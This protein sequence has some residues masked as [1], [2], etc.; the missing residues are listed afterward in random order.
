MIP[1]IILAAGES[2]RMGKPKMLLP[3]GQSTVLQTVIAAF[4]TAGVDQILIVCGRW[5]EHIRALVGGEVDTLFNADY[6][7]G[8]MLKSLQAG[9]AALPPD[10]EAALIGLG[11]QP[12]VEPEVV[13]HILQVYQ[14]TQAALVVPSYQMR[15]GHPWLAARGLWEEIEALPPADTLRNFLG[16]HS[17]SIVYVPLDSP[18]I[19]QDLDTPEDY[20]KY[21]P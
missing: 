20:L 19:L 12:Q 11:D 17:A 4:R 7:Q 8:G 21:K 3:W 15:R 1:A 13:R 9:L 6:A 16:R 5:Y 2:K 10:S 18:S 14:A